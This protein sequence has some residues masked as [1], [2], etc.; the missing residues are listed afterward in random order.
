[1]RSLVMLGE[2]PVTELQPHNPRLYRTCRLG[3]KKPPN[4]SPAAMDRAV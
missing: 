2:D 1:V 4:P 3:R